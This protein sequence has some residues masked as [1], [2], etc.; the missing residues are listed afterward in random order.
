MEPGNNSDLIKRVMK[1][2]SWFQ[3]A[4]TNSPF[5]NF[6]WKPTSY[7]IKYDELTKNSVRKAMIN[8]IENH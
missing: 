6:R 8:H 5:V 1:K 3:A 7:G 4:P 2:R